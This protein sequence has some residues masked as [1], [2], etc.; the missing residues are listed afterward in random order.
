MVTN[1]IHYTDKD[2]IKEDM[3]FFCC[4]NRNLDLYRFSLEYEHIRKIRR[5][6]FK[7]ITDVTKFNSADVHPC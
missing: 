7:K 4:K 2:I 1:I 3:L 5:F 6:S